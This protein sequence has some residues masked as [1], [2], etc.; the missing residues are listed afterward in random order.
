MTT[1]MTSAYTEHSP[2]PFAMRWPSRYVSREIDIVDANELLDCLT[3]ILEWDLGH[4]D[5]PALRQRCYDLITKVTG[6]PDPS[7]VKTFKGA[8]P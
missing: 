3:K 6:Y 8:Q 2:G 4:P 5:R 1:E 7:S